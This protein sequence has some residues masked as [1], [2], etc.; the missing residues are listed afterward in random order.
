MWEQ[1]Q[2]ILN[3][4]KHELANRKYSFRPLVISTP[5][6]TGKTRMALG[7]STFD[8]FAFD[9]GPRFI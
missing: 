7:A 6:G 5:P 3:Y 9:D 1:Q 4:A 2:S 8:T